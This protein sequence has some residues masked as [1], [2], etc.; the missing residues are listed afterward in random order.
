VTY[1][2]KH[3]RNSKQ[4]QKRI[5]FNDKHKR[6]SCERKRRMNWKFPTFNRGSKKFQTWW[7]QLGAETTVEKSKSVI[8][9]EKH[10]NLPD[11]VGRF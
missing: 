9:G 1:I 10:L 8:T 5:F 3:K 2:K 4:M 7:R 11:V 6:N